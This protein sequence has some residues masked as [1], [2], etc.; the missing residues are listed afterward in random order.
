MNQSCM[1]TNKSCEET[2]TRALADYVKS[3]IRTKDVAIKHKIPV[4]TLSKWVDESGIARR[5]RGRKT[6]STPSVRVQNILAHASIHGFS[7]AAKHFNITKQFVSSL[8]KRWKVRPP[9]EPNSQQSTQ[10][11]GV[12]PRPK[13][14]RR[15]IVVSFRLLCEELSSLRKA[16][17]PS[18]LQST[19]SPHKLARAAL[20]EHLEKSKLA[21]NQLTEREVKM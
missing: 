2:K 21:T 16:L 15:E 19:R 20:L 8:A 7:N 9:R 13:K 6:A 14:E 1:K 5:T 17:P 18:V 10:F 3:D 11:A 4:A 12:N